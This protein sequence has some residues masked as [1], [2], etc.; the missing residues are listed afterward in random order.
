ML[1]GTLG[2][3]YFAFLGT[4][5]QKELN[6][7]NQQIS[8]WSDSL[9]PIQCSNSSDQQQTVTDCID[10]YANDKKSLEFEDSQLSACIARK[11]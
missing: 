3:A 6:R 10:H 5:N 2:T 9:K 11:Q 1:A 8:Q 7:T 4:T